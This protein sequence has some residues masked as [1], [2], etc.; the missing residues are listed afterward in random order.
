MT[1][2]IGAVSALVSGTYTCTGIGGPA[3]LLKVNA[4]STGAATTLDAMTHASNATVVRDTLFNALISGTGLPVNRARCRAL[5]SYLEDAENISPPIQ[6][7]VFRAGPTSALFDLCH[8]RVAAF[9][10]RLIA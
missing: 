2:T 8:E 5:I 4:S 9:S 10:S 1:M 3:Q 7:L 6:P